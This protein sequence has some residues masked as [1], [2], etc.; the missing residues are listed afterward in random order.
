MSRSTESEAVLLNLKQLK[1]TAANGL[2]N[3]D[4]K[5]WEAFFN[6][7]EIQSYYEVFDSFDL[8]KSLVYYPET[9][10]CRFICRRYRSNNK[11]LPF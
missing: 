11:K 7:F 3:F 2:K 10:Y 9:G 4:Y 5:K 8:D 6:K 1:Q